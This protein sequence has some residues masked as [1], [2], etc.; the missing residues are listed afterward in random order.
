MKWVEMIKVLR[1]PKRSAIKDEDLIA[2]L[3]VSLDEF[4]QN[5]SLYGYSVV[6]DTM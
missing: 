3:K 5:S 1:S 6:E 2:L 4:I